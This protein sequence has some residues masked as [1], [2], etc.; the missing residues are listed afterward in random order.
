LISFFWQTKFTTGDKDHVGDEYF[1]TS[2]DKIRYFLEEDA[3]DGQGNLT[4]EKHKAVNKIGHGSPLLLFIPS[5]FLSLLRSYVT[6][7]A[8][9]N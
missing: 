2:G 1:L 4:R 5:W 3:I 9:M 7:Q 8:C 6:F